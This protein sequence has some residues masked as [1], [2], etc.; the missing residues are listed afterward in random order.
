M[1]GLE[2]ATELIYKIDLTR[3]TITQMI[4]GIHRLE[5]GRVD[6]SLLPLVQ[7]Q[8][9][10]E[11]LKMDMQK[12]GL[13]PIINHAIELFNFPI[14]YAFFQNAVEIFIHVPGVP[15]RDEGFQLYEISPLAIIEE[16]H[17]FFRIKT[18]ANLIAISQ[19]IEEDVKVIEISHDDFKDNCRKVNQHEWAC[20]RPKM[21]KDIQN[22]CL[23]AIY[24]DHGSQSCKKISIFEE[25]PKPMLKAGLI[26]SSKIT[27][28]LVT[29][30]VRPTE[31]SLNCNGFRE[32]HVLHGYQIWPTNIS[33]CEIYS[34]GWDISAAPVPVSEAEIVSK[35]L[36]VAE[37][38]TKP[39]ETNMEENNQAAA[40]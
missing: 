8:K 17:Q 24:F 19:G 9:A 4:L 5:E 6:P 32:S 38:T 7:A 2:L 3:E 30:F 40:N 18:A 13:R 25:F 22:N 14:S 37:V 39:L 35:A 33:R 28:Q 26:D 20:V 12:A 34:P 27:G 36:P 1:Q 11:K 15:I 21:I 29:F 31:I 16:N 10:L 23:S